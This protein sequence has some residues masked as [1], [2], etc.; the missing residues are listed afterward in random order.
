MHILSSL[1]NDV[2]VKFVGNL[3]VSNNTF[4]LPVANVNVLEH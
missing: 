3:V 4:Q 2:P 1:E